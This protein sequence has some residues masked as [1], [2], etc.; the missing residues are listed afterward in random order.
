MC[1]D[2]DHTNEET[3]LMHKLIETKCGQNSIYQV[4][5]KK[6]AALEEELTASS[7]NCNKEITKKESELSSQKIKYSELSSENSKLS[8]NFAT[9]KTQYESEIQSCTVEK[10]KIESE[11]KVEKQRCTLEKTKFESDIQAE[12]KRCETELNS[13]KKNNQKL[14]QQSDLL[15]V[16][17]TESLHKE[18]ETKMQQKDEAIDNLLE[19]IDDIAVKTE[20]L[21]VLHEKLVTS[22]QDDSEFY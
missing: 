10:T 5:K 21:K 20:K 7:N 6:F 18:C 22:L 16:A 1:I 14:N 13:H 11:I 15:W 9:A 17:K 4:L 19:I 8:S 3:L 2:R 12:K